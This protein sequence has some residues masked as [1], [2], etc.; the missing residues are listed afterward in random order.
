ML[1]VMSPHADHL[2]GVF[3]LIDLIDQSVLDID[4]TRIGSCQI[5]NQFLVTW[6]GLERILRHEIEEAMNL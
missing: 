6:R 2:D 3:G 4:P 1:V 5:T